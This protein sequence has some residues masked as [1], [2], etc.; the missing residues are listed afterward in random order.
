MQI[1]HIGYLV[2]HI[3]KSIEQFI[4]LG[5]IIK[6]D[7]VKDEI[8][9][10][11]ICFM[12]NANYLIELVSPYEKTSVVYPYFLKHKN[13]PYHICY[14][15]EN[16]DDDIIKLISDGYVVADP[17]CAAPAIDDKRVAFLINHRIGMIEIVED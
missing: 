3:E 9:Q 14:K 5:Y 6:S 4:K 17:P 8:R 7:I 10:V 15:S 11:D 2:K 12:Q 1:H 16:F 13:M